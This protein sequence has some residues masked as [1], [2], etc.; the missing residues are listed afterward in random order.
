MISELDFK[1]ELIRKLSVE[2]GWIDGDKEISD[3][4][5][6][7]ILN[8]R[9]KVAI[10]VKDDTVHKSEMPSPERPIICT[11]TDIG[12]MNKILSDH[13][14]KARIK[15][16]KYSD[17]K[18]ILLIRTEHRIMD[19]VRYAIDGLHTYTQ[20]SY[21]GRRGKYSEHTR[22]NIGCYIICDSD[23]GLHYIPNPHCKFSENLVSKREA[24]DILEQSLDEIREV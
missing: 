7:D 12:R 13:I 23:G 24:E 1:N 11:T 6:V 21:I 2:K 22:E 5:K 4:K 3:G 10:E 20:T 19:T 17:Y 16:K 8:H 18:T 15:F 9:K 14:K